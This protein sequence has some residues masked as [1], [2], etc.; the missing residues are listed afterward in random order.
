MACGVRG[1]SLRLQRGVSI[2]AGMPRAIV[3]GMDGGYG[4]G[5]FWIKSYS[6]LLRA[7]YATRCTVQK[8]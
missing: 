2:I 5:D 4:A 8:I 7:C 1:K 3:V 6:C